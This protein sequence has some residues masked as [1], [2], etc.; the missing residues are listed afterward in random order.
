MAARDLEGPFTVDFFLQPP[1]RTIHW[2]A[3]F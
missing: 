2:L 1:Q 3:F